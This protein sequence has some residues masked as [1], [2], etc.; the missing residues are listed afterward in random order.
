MNSRE[1]AESI[2]ASQPDLFSG[3][4]GEYRSTE[5]VR[6]LEAI[7]FSHSQKDSHKGSGFPE[8]WE[9]YSAHGTTT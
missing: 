8:L 7:D 4:I 5:V 2:S 6:L 1:A 9:S 3:V